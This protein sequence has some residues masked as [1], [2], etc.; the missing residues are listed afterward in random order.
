MTKS[1]PW[2]NTFH[3]ILLS[4]GSSAF[5]EL[6]S[7]FGSYSCSAL[8][9]PDALSFSHPKLTCVFLN[10]P[11]LAPGPLL[12]L[13]PWL[14]VPLPKLYLLPLP[15]PHHAFNYYRGSFVPDTHQILMP[16]CV[17]M[18]SWFLLSQTLALDCDCSGFVS[19][20]ELGRLSVPS[21][22]SKS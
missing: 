19:L 10:V 18:T 4:S 2:L 7:T 20:I 8:S 22:Q 16:T 6:G 5:S 12:M 3:S 17:L 21:L 13:F 14:G 11:F 15:P 9:L 1:F